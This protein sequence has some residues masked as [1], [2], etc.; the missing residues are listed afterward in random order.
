MDNKL[1]EHWHWTSMKISAQIDFK[2]ENLNNLMRWFVTLDMYRSMAMQW[3]GKKFQNFVG[4][5]NSSHTQTQTHRYT[6]IV[7]HTHTHTHRYTHTCIQSHTHTHTH[8]H[9]QTQTHTHTHTHRYIHTIHWS[10]RVFVLELLVLVLVLFFCVGCTYMYM[11]MYHT[12]QISF[13]PC[14]PH[15]DKFSIILCIL[16]VQDS[17]ICKTRHK[18]MHFG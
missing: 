1:C 13:V 17:I 11:Y 8:T 16:H 10:V 14:T 18:L 2:W 6:H 7:S 4:L 12:S 5:C 15:S 9:T 3:L